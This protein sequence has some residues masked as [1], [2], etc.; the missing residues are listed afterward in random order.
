MAILN[1]TA[2]DITHGPN[3]P[4]KKTALIVLK[5]NAALTNAFASGWTS[6]WFPVVGRWSRASVMFAWTL[7]DETS[8]QVEFETSEDGT[9]IYTDDVDGAPTAG[10]VTVSPL[11]LTYTKANYTTT[12]LIR[13]RLDVSDVG[14]FRVRAKAT[15]GTPTGTLAASVVC[16]KGDV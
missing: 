12:G 4:S 3:T 11:V 7:G 2:T 14:Y 1:I 5:A 16:G 6:S 15:G 8:M 10:A 9:V 13:R